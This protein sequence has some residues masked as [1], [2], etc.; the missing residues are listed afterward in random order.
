[1]GA[2]GLLELM[3][4]APEEWAAA[5]ANRRIH[6]EI[7]DEGHWARIEMTAGEDGALTPRFKL[8][9]F[10]RACGG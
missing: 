2:G 6:F 7:Y 3:R 9:A 5:G 8:E 1:M 4:A 10:R